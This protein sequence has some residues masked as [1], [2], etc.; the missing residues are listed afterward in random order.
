ML[1]EATTHT[2]KGK[3]SLILMSNNSVQHAGRHLSNQY[4]DRSEEEQGRRYTFSTR[5]GRNAS[6]QPNPSTDRAGRLDLAGV[7]LPPSGTDPM[8]GVL[9]AGLGQ[10]HAS[11]AYAARTSNMFRA[12]PV[13]DR[14]CRWTLHPRS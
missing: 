6:Q 9:P 4:P 7:Y 12:P 2:Q 11:R 8:P 3:L 1:R 13:P 14:A 5:E 10:Q